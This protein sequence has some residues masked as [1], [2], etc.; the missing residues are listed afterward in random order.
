MTAK[1]DRA[2]SYQ[3][4]YRMLRRCE[5]PDDIGYRSYGGRGIKVCERW[6]DFELYYADITRLL[7]PCPPRKSMDRI[8][9]DGGYEPGNVRW[10][11]AGEQAEN[12]RTTNPRTGLTSMDGRA[13]NGSFVRAMRKI[14]CITR[15]ELATRCGITVDELARIESGAPDVSASPAF[16]IA[17]AMGVSLE[18]LSRPVIQAVPSCL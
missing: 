3:R 14:L 13:I 5:N 2:R 12:R 18:A 10:A 4:W 8:D 16:A 9:N 11:T 17:E 1:N 15:A 6:H 7:G